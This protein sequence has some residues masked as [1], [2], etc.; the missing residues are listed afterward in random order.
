[1]RR[2]MVFCLAILVVA[3]VVMST[4]P[5]E[6]QSRN[7]RRALG[8]IGGI[9]AGT[10]ILKELNKGVQGAPRVS[11]PTRPRSEPRG[12]S[13]GRTERDDDEPDRA[14]RIELQKALVAAGYDIGEPD[15]KFGERTRTAIRTYQRSI[16]VAPTG[17]LTQSQRHAL[18]GV[19][20]GGSYKPAGTIVP[21]A[22]TIPALHSS[23]SGTLHCEVDLAWRRVRTIHPL[24]YQG[25]A[26]CENAQT[27]EHVIVLAE[28]PPHLVRANVEGIVKAL[29]GAPV[30]TV[31]TKR[32]PL[33]F[34]GWV[35]DLV[36]V[37][38]PSGA[39][40]LAEFNG[41]LA[42]LA[43]YAFGSAY[44]AEVL[45]IAR[46]ETAPLWS[47][48]PALEVTAE[49]LH[50]WL[51]GPNAQRLVALE[52]GPAARLR[53]RA[54]RGETGTYHTEEP[55]LVV[56]IVPAGSSS[57]LND[58][59]EDLRRFAVDTD[60]FLGAIRLK[61]DRVALIGRERTTSF[62]EMP[63]LRVE[64]IVLLASVKGSD[65]AQSYERNRPFAGK[66]ESGSQAGWD[67]API[68]L[69]NELHD[70]EYGS[71]LNFTDNMLKGWSM[72]G[73][74][75]YH[76][77]PHA[78]PP[79]KDYPFGTMGAMKALNTNELV[80][81][82]NT[83]GVGYLTRQQGVEVYSVRNSGSL[84]VSYFPEGTENNAGAKVSLQEAEDK[85]YR[86]FRE[87]RNPML[88]R[89]V[90]YAALYQAFLAFEVRAAE[91][92]DQAA[93]AAR[94]ATFEATIS[95]HQS[96]APSNQPSDAVRAEVVK[97]TWREPEGWVR[98]PSIV[99]SRGQVELRSDQGRNFRI[100]LV[101]GHNIGGRATRVETGSANFVSQNDKGAWII[102][103]SSA[104]ARYGRDLVRMFDRDVNDIIRDVVQTA[105]RE[106]LTDAALQARLRARLDGSV[107][108]LLKE[109]R[110]KG[111]R[112]VRP[113]SEMSA[114]LGYSGS[115][116]RATRGAEISAGA[117]SVGYRAQ[118]A[119]A[120]MPELQRMATDLKA[121][122]VIARVDEG[123]AIVRIQPHPPQT[124][125]STNST[126]LLSA[127]DGQV[128]VVALG[129]PPVKAPKIISDGS[130]TLPDMQRVVQSLAHRQQAAAGAGGKPPFG[131][132][133]TAFAVAEGPERGQ[134]FQHLA[135]VRT[136]TKIIVPDV[137]AGAGRLKVSVQ[138]GRGA[139]A[140]L[141]LKPRWADAQINLSFREPGEVTFA[142]APE[143]QGAYLHVIEVRVPVETASGGLKSL[144][145]DALA[146]FKARLTG[147][148]LDEA[149][150]ALTKL[151]RGQI[152]H[153]LEGALQRYK[154][155]M[156]EH[157]ADDFKIRIRAEGADFIVTEAP[158]RSQETPRG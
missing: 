80:F 34:D 78:Y 54:D 10:I 98:T 88:E 86:Y 64:S 53:D 115:A 147:A 46:M 120:K 15:G 14:E 138:S 43:K 143:M 107:E 133:R 31:M 81:N 152:K 68:L 136:D 126:S 123:F 30:T 44:K 17:H 27:G 111:V 127:V 40:Q 77:F 57:K 102:T 151:F 82:W 122:I 91:P 96:S 26:A 125:V 21:A 87:L 118:P 3:A 156:K 142:H 100:I 8:I 9:A 29:V 153:D 62:A 140:T 55:G 97:A 112:P 146:S 121:D 65:L 24:H 85:A 4:V 45:D 101:G 114:A 59:V 73:K 83:A 37:A 41:G 105:K 128:R 141:P 119:S 70:T 103:V 71:L 19:P 12:P 6:G 124:L 95:K 150:G 47:A 158:H 36:I 109:L 130:V 110:S 50:E 66:L 155:I 135:A 137:Q 2:I 60:V 139:D 113:T 134:Q 132:D 61:Q 56:A 94:T 1:M 89:A 7:A 52:G 74:V 69:S 58:H 157:G 99:L 154:G 116:A 5:A 76:G 72:S 67:W 131:R 148:R 63:P 38:R 25:I 48:P 33:G 117:R 108:S 75:Q 32:H 22:Q 106:N 18:L 145:V 28:P 92:H 16:G 93:N 20:G 90:Q 149:N 51:I 84:P 129:P 23:P 13:Q 42:L 39:E 104:D 144:L 49:E 79:E 35:D 11:I